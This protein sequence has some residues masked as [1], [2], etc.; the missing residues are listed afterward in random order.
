[1]TVPS[2][3]GPNDEYSVV[4]LSSCVKIRDTYHFLSEFDAESVIYDKVGIDEDHLKAFQ[5]LNPEFKYEIHK[6][7]PP[8]P[9]P[10]RIPTIDMQ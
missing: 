8:R 5:L 7:T 9:V 2:L 6:E 3:Q 4:G 10:R 1:M